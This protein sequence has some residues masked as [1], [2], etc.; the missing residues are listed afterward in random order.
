MFDLHATTL[1][2]LQKIGKADL[3]AA[4]SERLLSADSLEK[5]RVA[6]AESGG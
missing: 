4:R 3:R 1:T 6:S 5:Q 2:Q